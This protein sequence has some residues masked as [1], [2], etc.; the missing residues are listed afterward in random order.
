MAHVLLLGHSKHAEAIEK[1]LAANFHVMTSFPVVSEGLNAIKFL[2]PEVILLPENLTSSGRANL[3]EKLQ[4]IA[5]SARLVFLYE[6][7]ID[8][9]QFADAIVDTKGD[10]SYLPAA[11]DYVCVNNGSI[12]R[13]A[14]AAA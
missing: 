2:N 5:P 9:A 3:V 10:P 8:S 13:S 7:Y 11:I 1:S 12:W 6:H 14:V 4:K